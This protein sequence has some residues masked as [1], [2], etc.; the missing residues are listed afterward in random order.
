MH[1]WSK[2]E[3]PAKTPTRRSS[4]RQASEAPRA[5]DLIEGTPCP[6]DGCTLSWPRWHDGQPKCKICALDESLAAMV[7]QGR[8]T[9]RPRKGKVYIP[10]RAPQPMEERPVWWDEEE[11]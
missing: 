7:A 3:A 6:R 8:L 11:S 9:H 4:R 2:Y 10:P 1:L 5:P